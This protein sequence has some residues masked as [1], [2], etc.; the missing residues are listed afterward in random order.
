MVEVP[1]ELAPLTVQPDK[2]VLP[3]PVVAPVVVTPAPRVSV[4]RAGAVM[5]PLNAIVKLEDEA[6]DRLPLEATVPDTAIPML[7]P[8][9]LV[10]VPEREQSERWSVR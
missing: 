6:M 9:T 4:V 5:L 7:V 3:V 2:V 1:I 8:A 10:I